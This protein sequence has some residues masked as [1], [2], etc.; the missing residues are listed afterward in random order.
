MMGCGITRD[1]Y[2][3]LVSDITT[4]HTIAITTVVINT[5]YELGFIKIVRATGP[6]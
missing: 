6:S 3:T 1:D 4:R 5:V 2:P